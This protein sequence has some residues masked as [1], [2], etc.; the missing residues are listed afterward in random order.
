MDVQ[1]I[2]GGDIQINRQN[3]SAA[4]AE[5]TLSS[6]PT[7]ALCTYRRSCFTG[8]DPGVSSVSTSLAICSGLPIIPC[9]AKHCM[10]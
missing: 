3:F 5:A 4:A 7:F 8:I 6:C 2:A 9:R 10:N 1:H